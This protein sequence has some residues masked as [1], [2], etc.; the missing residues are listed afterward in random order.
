MLFIPS[1]L[2]ACVVI[3]FVLLLYFYI[4][5]GL[6]DLGFGFRFGLSLEI[7]FVTISGLGP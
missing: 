1:C 6:R 2:Y 4:V 3:N 5:V 7:M